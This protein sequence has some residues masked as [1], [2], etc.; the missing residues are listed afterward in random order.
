MIGMT[1]LQEA[2]LAREAEMCFATIALATDYDCWRESS[3]EVN[4]D[5]I[6]KVMQANVATSKKILS[7]AIA[8][9]PAERSCGCGEAL[10]YAILT[11]LDRIPAAARESLEPIIGRYLTHP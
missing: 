9:I 5:A 4:V 7:E 6:L 11:P 2:K 3:E 8:T 10:K 1:N